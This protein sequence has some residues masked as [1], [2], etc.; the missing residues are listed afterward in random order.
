MSSI[1]HL[2]FVITRAS[3]WTSLLH[4]CSASSWKSIFNCTVSTDCL[5]IPVSNFF[6]KAGTYFSKRYQTIIYKVLSSHHKHFWH[7]RLVCA[8]QCSV[9]QEQEPLVQALEFLPHPCHFMPGTQWS[10]MKHSQCPITGFQS[11]KWWG[12]W[13]MWITWNKDAKENSKRTQQSRMCNC[14]FH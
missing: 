7:S 1:C 5:S 10:P 3:S 12:A 11:H 4:P 13:L 6:K 9:V 14:D 8:D 2:C